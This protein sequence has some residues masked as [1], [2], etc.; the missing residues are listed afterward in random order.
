MAPTDTTDTTQ[1]ILA[2]E[3]KIALQWA[4]TSGTT[5]AH[6][7]GFSF[8]QPRSAPCKPL[9]PVASSTHLRVVRPTGRKP[10]VGSS[11]LAFALLILAFLGLGLGY[12]AQ[13]AQPAKSQ[14]TAPL[15]W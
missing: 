2:T 5:L 11:T 14:V 15:M 13:G 12:V 4:K 3:E 6:S 9:S 8:R 10:R 1:P 7:G